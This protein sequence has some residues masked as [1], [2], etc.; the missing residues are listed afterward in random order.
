MVYRLTWVASFA[1]LGL[2]VLRLRRLFLPTETGLPW[3]VV[4]LAAGLLGVVLTWATLR[5]RFGTPTVLL[6]HVLVF[7]L[8]TFTYVGGELAGTTI[9]PID[10]AGDILTEVSDA[11]TIFR[12]SAPPVTPLAG[13]VVLAA[14]MVWAL[15]AVATWG[16]LN[17]S[18]YLG[19]VPPVVFYLQLAVIDRQTTGMLWT[20]TLLVL[21]G[22]GLAAIAADQRTG[23]GHAGPGRQKAR[24]QAFALPVLAILSVTAVSVFATRQA[25]RAE[26]VPS[27]GLLDWTNRAGIGG[28]FGSISYNPFIDVQRRLVSNSPQP[29]FAA[30][31]QGDVADGEL[32]WRLLTMDNFN[33]D[34]WYA[35][36]DDL[37]KLDE[38]G[39]E[40]DAYEFR[41]E[42]RAVQQDVTILDLGSA[43]L[44]AAYSPVGLFSEER[45]IANTTR[46]DPIDGSLHI[47]GVTSRG[48]TYRIQSQVPNVNV[49]VLAGDE[50]GALSPLFR[51]AAGEG[52]FPPVPAPAP[53]IDQPRD[54]DRYTQLPRG[55][56]SSGRLRQLADGITFGLETDYEKA[57]ALEHFFRDA[58]LFQYSTNVA[59]NERD[60]GLE[61]WLLNP[62]SPGYRVGYCE[63]FSASMGVLA[64]LLDIPTRTVLGFTPG[65]IRSDGTVL[66]RDRNAHAWVEVWLP[67]QGW[68]RFD[69]TP[70]SDGVNPTT[71]EETGFSADDLDRYFTRIDQAARDALS[72]AGGGGDPAV[73]DP[74][75]E[76]LNR[77]PGGGG[78]DDALG[79]GGLSLPGWL[80]PAALLLVIAAVILSVVPAIKRRRR[81]RRLRRLRD[82]DIAAAWA[83]IV[84]RL[85][86]SG[87]G[88]NRAATP[89]EVAG[90]TDTALEPLAEVYSRSVYGPD[91]QVDAPSVD[92]ALASLTAT[93][94]RLRTRESRWRRI[95]RAYR[96]RSLLPDWI[97]KARRR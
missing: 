49:A 54:I 14:M 88:L 87:V 10:V 5:A 6:V 31:V 30:S 16:L 83:E 19:I 96:L 93:E 43:W 78:G 63:Q 17:A 71:F 61:D 42:T 3:P 26:A 92:V 55:F 44:P 32:Y 62:A 15:S 24:I 38:T 1:L 48:M 89:L 80:Q 53:T 7:S 12:F 59:P 79:G 95:R 46:I 36:N 21:V 82:G 27:T 94:E 28:G 2:V 25:V 9:P 65:E 56:D 40:E 34:W 68:V 77:F 45:I 11:L 97:K 23:G 51:E 57:L 90:S 64:R 22:S 84:D 74:N 76:E 69:P 37:E 4:V 73:R 60:S 39:W 66:V 72:S 13:I 35:S 41:G 8:F 58:A 50:D 75:L 47:D 81:R 70:R 18:P 86:D 33:G 52:R 20:A 91:P 85:I 67:A 29:V